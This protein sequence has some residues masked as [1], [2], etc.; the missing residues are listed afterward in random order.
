[1]V[2]LQPARKRNRL[3]RFHSSSGVA[4]R[5]GFRD[6]GLR[7]K[8]PRHTPRPNASA[9]P[10]AAGLIPGVYRGLR[11]LEHAGIDPGYAAHLLTLP[12]AHL[13]VAVMCNVETNGLR[14]TARRVA[15]LYLGQTAEPLP[16]ARPV[17]A[18]AEA[19]LRAA[20]GAYRDAD[21]LPFSV[22][23]REGKLFLQGQDEM[24]PLGGGT[25]RLKGPGLEMSVR[26]NALI[27][28]E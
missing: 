25:F 15:D 5:C 14:E 26:G 22:E 9:T 3:R 24:E 23:W 27:L 13:G 8:K 7:P 4:L 2:L 19:D 11:T 6:R 21:D 1:A 18:V 20:A 10:Y 16:A 28:H 12:D 17:V